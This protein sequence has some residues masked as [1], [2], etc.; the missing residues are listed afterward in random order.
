[1]SSNVGRLVCLLAFCTH[2][3]AKDHVSKASD[4]QGIEWLREIKDSL[5]K[6]IQGKCNWTTTTKLS[7]SDNYDLSV[8][9]HYPSK[10]EVRAYASI[11]RTITKG[12]PKLIP[13]LNCTRLRNWENEK[14]ERWM[15][16]ADHPGQDRPGHAEVLSD[17]TAE[18]WRAGSCPGRRDRR[19]GWARFCVG[20]ALPH[21]LC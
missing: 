13:V 21:V 6:N 19:D 2:S 7:V 8:S 10:R 16:A 4:E 1:M 9:I 12:N 17:G 15:V 20:A 18:Q 14:G 11:P 5:R 3:Q